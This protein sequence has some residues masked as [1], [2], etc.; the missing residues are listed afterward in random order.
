M[1]P[2]HPDD[3]DRDRRLDEVATA[4]LKAVEA[5]E[6][7]DTQEWLN[8]HPDLA[9]ELA[10]FFAAQEQ[11]DRIAAPLREATSGPCPGDTV[12]YFG[13]YE[14]LEE[15]ARGGM[16]VVFKARQVSLNRTVALKMILTGQLASE[17][18]VQRFRQEAE[19]AAHLDHPHIVPIY[20][21]G[22]HQGQHYFSMRL[23]EGGSLAEQVGRGVGAGGGKDQQ[24]K[25]AR[26][27][28]AVARAVHHAHQRGILHRDLK[29]A[30]ILLDAKGEPV[31]TDFGLAKRV[32][33]PGEGAGEAGLTH[34]GAVVGTPRY[35][36]PEQAS[37][38]KV[39]STAVDVYS[40]GAILYE[41]LTGRPPFWAEAPLETLLAVVKKEPEPPRRL[42]PHVDRDLETICLKCLEKD[43]E[44][45]YG[46][47]EALA[48]DLERWLAGEPIR[49]RPVGRG[50]RLWRWCRRQPAVA[51]LAATVALCLVAGGVVSTS[52]AIL[53]ADNATREKAARQEAD[54]SAAAALAN[55]RKAR[56]EGERA[57][58][59]E[60]A[61]LQNLYVSHVNQAH[62]AWQMA[63]VGRVR[64]LLDGQDPGKTGKPDFRGF[65]WH[66][67]DRL[68]HSNLRTLTGHD[69]WVLSVA[70]SPDGKYIASAGGDGLHQGPFEIRVWDARTGQVVHRLWGHRSRVTG[71]TFSPDGKHLASVGRV[72]KIW[73]VTSG[74]VISTAAG[75]YCVAFSPVGRLLAAVKKRNP[76][77]WERDKVIVWDWAAGKEVRAINGIDGRITS[78]AFSP[79]GKRLAAGGRLNWAGGALTPFAGV[80]PS[81]RIWEVDTGKELRILQ[82]PGGVSAVAFNRDGTRLASAGGKNVK[83]WDTKTGRE[84]LSLGGHSWIVSSVAYSR[85]GK[86][87]AS[88]S[89]DETVRVWDATTGKELVVLKGH[90]HGVTAVAFSPDGRRLVSAA[91]DKTV[92]VWDITKDPEAFT[93][94]LAGE[95]LGRLA[96][97][98]DGKRLAYGAVGVT[99]WDV[100][101]GKHVRSLKNFL[102]KTPVSAVAFSRDG[103]RLA[104]ASPGLTDRRRRPAFQ[105]EVKVWD[106]ETGKQISS[107]DLDC[108][109]SELAFSPDG[110]HLI[111][112]DAEN[113]QIR[114]V[115]S[116]KKEIALK[117][118]LNAACLAYSPDG[119]FL[120]TGSRSSPQ[121]QGEVNL[122]DLVSGKKI[123]SL[124]KQEGWIVSLGF[125]P[126]GRRLASA[127]S[128]GVKVWNTVTGKELS[129]FRLTFSRVAAF[130]GDGKRLATSGVYPKVNVWDVTTGQQLLSLNGFGNLTHWLA[131]SPDGTR[132]A[133]SGSEDGK[134]ASVR[135]WDGTP[136]GRAKGG[137]P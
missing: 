62:L 9:G 48:E 89:T 107:F 106:T 10:T 124:G 37:A 121:L 86:R 83:V 72:V 112:S 95:S 24:K 40:L 53:A 50:E 3:A 60:L 98:P 29:P 71:V 78:L 57:R 87:L 74:K 55:E 68:C 5:G 49:A 127:A 22:E 75:A 94:G 14:L 2:N 105:L 79:D 23:V 12:R 100:T 129:T 93:F 116:G 130:S 56:Q 41:L 44:R 82:H 90:T 76:D 26:L 122:W 70:Y 88:G 35:M 43:P 15:I 45:R 65:E 39:L 91:G 73:D 18:D 28:A 58:R 118:K 97:H 17:G 99:L 51:A 36:A 38:S 63:Q 137:K 128:Y 113:G 7:P 104:A 77:R 47:A 32:A 27:M 92:K 109:A 110:K 133:A 101:K 66:Y 123:R 114:N 67:L 30:N 34:S 119:R 115:A 96:F 135:V 132:L 120:A 54:K 64:Q 117:E 13:D 1:D 21:V 134:V 59:N 25:A 6:K 84:V 11:V 20:E 42:N 33:R 19:A 136:R 4:Y 16:G 69:H 125:S 126:D 31:V 52:L 102:L 85:D 131:F 61:A 108:F 80:G 81:V 8:R 103:K 46:S 111:I